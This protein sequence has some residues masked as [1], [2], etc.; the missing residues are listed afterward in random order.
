MSVNQ[1]RNNIISKVSCSDKYLDTKLISNESNNITTNSNVYI[2]NNYL[3][4]KSLLC[5]SNNNNDLLRENSEN[6]AK[7]IKSKNNNK[8]NF[9]FDSKFNKLLNIDIHSDSDDY[10]LYMQEISLEKDTIKKL[11]NLKNEF[12][13]CKRIANSYKSDKSLKTYYEEVNDSE[14]R[15]N[16]AL[17]KSKFKKNL[18]SNDILSITNNNLSDKL[19]VENNNNHNNNLNINHKDSLDKQKDKDI[20]FD[21]LEDNIEIDL[22]APANSSLCFQ[23]DNS[24]N[25]FNSNRKLLINNLDCVKVSTMSTREY[26]NRVVNI[27]TTALKKSQRTKIY[28]R[29]IFISSGTIC[30]IS[31]LL[32]IFWYFSYLYE[33]SKTD[34]ILQ[35]TACS[36][37][38]LFHL[39]IIVLINCFF[40]HTPYYISQKD[41]NIQIVKRLRCYKI[42]L[43]IS[44][45]IQILDCI[46]II[47]V[48]YIDYFYCKSQFY[49]I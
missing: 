20:L 22:K 38:L 48:N 11:N 40:N 21:K 23:V 37:L 39:L 33:I 14:D 9:S 12:D 25:F 1:K 24:H 27:I 45:F 5:E 30:V 7:P 3:N 26:E 6:N 13:E 15:K 19:I 2:N 47:L 49:Y 34:S 4:K 10:N 41:A 36:L 8:G 35:Y 28:L 44:L 46:R 18:S 42:L 43:F 31:V 32:V 29:R 16:K 17:K